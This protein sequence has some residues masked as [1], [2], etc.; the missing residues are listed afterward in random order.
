MNNQTPALSSNVISDPRAIERFRLATLRAAVR[1]EKVGMK[2]RG[3]S[4]K[5]QAIMELDL[6]SRSNHDE[7]IAALSA[8]M[9]EV[10]PVASLTSI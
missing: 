7:V 3:Q 9:E 8:K 1:L 10:F 6:A 4:A 2:R 5:K